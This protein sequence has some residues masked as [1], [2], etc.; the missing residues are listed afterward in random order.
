[1]GLGED[2]ARRPGWPT[3]LLLVALGV[4]LSVLALAAVELVLAALGVGEEALYDDPFVGF[5]G[6]SDLFAAATLADGREVYRTRPEKLAFFNEQTFAAEK[7]EGGYRVFA[8]GG[9]TTAGRPYDDRVA[10][11]RWLQL[12]LEAADPDRAWEVVNAGAISYASYRV[13]LLM[14][15][16]VEYEP[17]LFVIYTGHNEFL[18]ERT[19]SDI[20]H[21]P[22]AVKRLRMWLSGFRFA[23]LLRQ[24]LGGAD[25]APQVAGEDGDAPTTLAP[26]VAARLDRYAGLE[27]YERDDEL[28][29]SVLEHFELNLRRMVR[30]A[31]DHGAEV[32]FVQPVSNVADFSPFRSQHSPDLDPTAVTRF[33][34]LLQASRQRLDSRD[35]A[36]AVAALR[37]AVEIDP[38]HAEAWFRLGR[39]LLAAGDP[40]AAHD[41]FVRAK[42]EDVAPLRALE[43][44]VAA[45]VRV[46]AEEE[47]PLIPLRDQLQAESLERFGR[48]SLGDEYLLD[49]VHPDVPVHSRIAEQVLDWLVEEGEAEP[50]PGWGEP[51]RRALYEEE[52]GTFDRAYYARRDLNLSKVLGWAGK[53]EEAEEP[54][55][56]ASREIPEEPEVWLNLGIV[57]QRTGRPEASLEA[58]RRAEAL[59]PGW[60]LVHFNLGVTLGH[61]DRPAE[62]TAAL[63]RA[64]QVR[65]DYPEAQRN[66]AA[67]LREQG[68]LEESLAV[69]DRLATEGETG[70]GAVPRAQRE[71]ARDR[72]L[73]YRRQGRLEEAE[74]LLRRLVEEEATA[75]VLTDLAVTLARQGRL[76]EAAS[77]LGAALEADPAY[78][79]A[80]YNLGVVRAARG[81]RSAAEAA[82]R[83]TLDLAPRHPEAHNNLGVILAGRGDLESALEHFRTAMEADPEWAEAHFNRGV[84]LDRAGRPAE[85]LAAVER[86]VALE[87]AEPR[88]HLALG[89]LYAAR[90]RAADALRHLEVARAGGQPVPEELL[91][92]LR[93]RAG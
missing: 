39:A 49:H 13:A 51:A 9:S 34:D 23:G 21:Q 20:I 50:R 3:R 81:D 27:R 63:R 48:P 54:L 36:G 72:A 86:A 2:K 7:P 29:G 65:P 83:R 12:Y 52:L 73:V 32:V 57:Y 79:E 25:E 40:G 11:A 6:R 38:R 17:D 43:P 64:L 89:S 47:V 35:A 69:L 56:R 71:V 4:V 22:A 19:Y 58:L 80:H 76:D 59:A 77:R 37:E 33:T 18:E 14:R 15:E 53:L 93:R 1:M 45:V 46:A 87:P 16:L 91:A 10:F 92:D 90:G 60:E 66:L 55:L 67:L 62:A 24:A 78:A 26:E 75:P 30:I 28:A 44:I 42:D 74:T 31:R 84:A 85:A 61:L 41:A 68:E 8:V 70:S 5:S 88:F 82:Y